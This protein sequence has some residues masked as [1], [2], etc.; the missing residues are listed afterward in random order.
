MIAVFGAGGP[1]GFA[2]GP[3][4]G[5]HHRST[6]S[7]WSIPA[8]FAVSAVLSVGTALLVAFGSREVRPEVVPAGLGAPPRLRGGPGRPRGPG[9]PADLRDLRRG[10]PGQPDDA[11]RTSR[12]SSRRIDGP[13]RAWRAPSALVAGT[14][15]LVGALVVADRRLDRRPDRVPAGARRRR[16]VGGGRRGPADAAGRARAGPGARRRRPRRGV[17][18]RVGAMVFGLLGDRGPAGAPLGDAQ[19]GL[20]AAVPRRDRGPAAGVLRRHVRD[21]RAVRRGRRRLRHRRRARRRPGAPA[22]RIRGD[23]AAGARRRS[24]GGTIESRLGRQRVEPGRGLRPAGRA[25]RDRCSACPAG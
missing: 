23:D 2:V 4:L 6:G 24:S 21:R 17:Q 11:G 15:A 16:C 12:C 14:A 25:P 9:R 22:D 8:V 7:G 13:V 20:S 5:G 1:I 10:V 3:V 18:R 19:P